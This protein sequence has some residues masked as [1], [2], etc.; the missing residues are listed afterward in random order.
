MPP[1]PGDRGRRCSLPRIGTSA[2]AK[3]PA[4]RPVGWIPTAKPLGWC[5]RA[6]TISP[7]AKPPCSGGLNKAVGLCRSCGLCDSCWP[8]F[9]WRRGFGQLPAW[10]RFDRLEERVCF[11]PGKFVPGWRRGDSAEGFNHREVISCPTDEEL[12]SES[13]D[14]CC[15]PSPRSTSRLKLRLR[16]TL[17][18]RRPPSR[19]DTRFQ[20]QPA[21]GPC[22]PG[23]MRFAVTPIRGRNLL[24]RTAIRITISQT[25]SSAC[26][27][28]PKPGG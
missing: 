18:V 3:H 5:F 4:F 13:A 21:R 27:S 2:P 12:L 10:D 26:G 24:P 14:G 8:R 16:T 22:P 17:P 15:W 11:V 6:T 20:Y 1:L 25:A 28:V 19:R 23:W 9:G 7:S